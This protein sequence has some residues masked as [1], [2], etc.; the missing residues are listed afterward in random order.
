MTSL[1]RLLR[2][3]RAGGD[4][5]LLAGGI[6]VPDTITVTSGAFQDGGTI[7]VKYAGE[8]VGGDNQSPALRWS[9]G[10][11][12]GTE[13][14][15]LIIEDDDVPLPRPLMHTIAILEPQRDHIDE[16]ALVAP[17]TDFR[18]IKNT[19]WAWILRAPPPYPATAA[20]TTASTCLR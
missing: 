4:R 12:Q 10:V 20:T 13:A 1:G 3:V 6:D 9:G 2:S 11:P 5:S 19:A 8:G 18:F 17:S 14:L 16:D 7:P 15:V